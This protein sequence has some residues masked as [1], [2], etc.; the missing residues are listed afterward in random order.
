MVKYVL[1][2]KTIIFSN[3]FCEQM[4]KYYWI[5][6]D[7]N[8][9]IF[10]QGN[11]FSVFNH[12]ITLPR[13]IK[14]L[15]FSVCFNQFIFLPGHIKRL[16]FGF[17]F[18]QPIIL[19]PHIKYVTFDHEF[20]QHFMLTSGITVLTLGYNFNQPIILTLD[21]THLTI[22]GCF[23]QSII[24]TPRITHLVLGFNCGCKFG[25]SIVLTPRITY[26]KLADLYVYPI[27]L[28]QRIKNLWIESDNYYIVDN[29]TNNIKYITLGNHFY[30]PLENVPSCNPKIDVLNMKYSHRVF[31]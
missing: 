17:A 31:F 26:L 23:N 16:E 20:N 5:I 10:G 7:L 19:T 13:Y 2:G 21:I 11:C 24:L 1:Y 28:T 18:N 4:D 14:H 8:V 3:S 6:K 9:I 30:L 25:K 12:P 22:G 29:L 27:I 15:K